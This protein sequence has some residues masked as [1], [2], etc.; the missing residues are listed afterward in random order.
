MICIPGRIQGKG[1]PRFY[2][3]RAVTPEAT[4]NYEA[5]IA[6]AYKASIRSGEDVYH[7]GPVSVLI[8]VDYAI[9]ESYSKK[10]KNM[11]SCD[12]IR[13]TKKPDIDN[14]AKAVLDGLNGVAYKDDTQVVCLQVIKGWALGTEEL[15]VYV[16]DTPCGEVS[17]ESTKTS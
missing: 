2:G 7:E 6:E 12:A 13:P 16:T 8:T 3:H 5:K 15:R 10:K 1:R 4:V 17:N 9:P 14:V 11:C